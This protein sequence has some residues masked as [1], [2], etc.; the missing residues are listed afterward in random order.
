MRFK[1]QRP[2]IKFYWNTK[3]IIGCLYPTSAE[4]PSCH[5][6]HVTDKAKNIHYPA[7][8]RN[9]LLIP[10]LDPGN[11]QSLCSHG[12]GRGTQMINTVDKS[13][14]S[15]ITAHM[16]HLKD[17]DNFLTWIIQ[18]TFYSFNF[19]KKRLNDYRAPPMRQK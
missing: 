1:I 2:S 18:S 19:K 16:Y 5:R 14:L 15:H 9:S 12:A 4:L 17:K 7:L 10:A 8:C 11:S 3:L 6:H 13:T